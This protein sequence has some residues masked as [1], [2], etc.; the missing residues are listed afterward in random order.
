MQEKKSNPG[1]KTAVATNWF[2]KLGWLKNKYILATVIFGVWMIFFDRNDFLVQYK[3]VARAKQLK[4]QEIQKEELITDTHKELKLL[5]TSAQTLEK[6]ARENHLM[7]KDNED[8]FVVE[9][10]PVAN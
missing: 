6:Y 1:T 2:G 7:K 10:A 3:R 9:A 8:L 5:Q 4:A